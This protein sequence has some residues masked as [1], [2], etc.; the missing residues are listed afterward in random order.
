MP[1]PPSPAQ[2]AVQ[3][4]F[5]LKGHLKNV[6]VA[7]IRVAALL[8][9]LRD[10]GLYRALGHPTMEDYGAKRLGLQRAS[11]YNYLRIHDWIREFH[12]AW[13][14]RRP[15]G[16]IPELTDAYALMWIEH[17]LKDPKLSK[18]I[19]AQLEALRK[20]AL[21]GALTLR[22]F[23][24]FRR[25]WRGSVPPLRVVLATVRAARRRAAQIP[26]LAADLLHA[27]D[28]LIGRIEA[29]IATPAHVRIVV[30][31]RRVV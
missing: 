26:G 20:K 27:F 2:R 21:A 4:T 17:R 29:G 3:I 28:A 19:R 5:T 31:K 25:Q 7:Y 24:Q 16:F 10:E 18:A 11:L 12:P 8:A 13:L 30:S 9:K 15:R 14:E 6:R 1:R 23:Q 22:E